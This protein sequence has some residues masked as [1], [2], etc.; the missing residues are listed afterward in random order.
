MAHRG[1]HGE[2]ATVKAHVSPPRLGVCHLL[3][4]SSPN[5]QFLPLSAPQVPT[6]AYGP[7]S[8]TQLCL[9][10]AGVA[11]APSMTPSPTHRA[12]S[13]KEVRRKAR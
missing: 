8:L 4:L 7:P 5:S 2:R 1:D 6:K 12:L 3:H 11:S 10:R 13:T 9:W